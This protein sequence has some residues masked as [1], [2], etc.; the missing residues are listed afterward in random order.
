[1]KRKKEPST[2]SQATRP[3]SGG[4]GGWSAGL[5]AASTGAASVVPLAC[6]GTGCSAVEVGVSAPELAADC[7]SV[8]DD[9]IFLFWWSN[10][11]TRAVTEG[12]KK[13]KG[14]GSAG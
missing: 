12:G 6:A 4:G 9:A 11:N 14:K 1:M 3:P 2:W 7:F 8:S 5:D 13:Q 10:E